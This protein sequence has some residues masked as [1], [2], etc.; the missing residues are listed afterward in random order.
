MK[1]EVLGLV[2]LLAVALPVNIKTEDSFISPI[3]LAQLVSK[4][5]QEEQILA[6]HFLDLTK[7]HKVNSVN[8]IFCDNIL[9]TLH[10]LEGDVDQFIKDSSKKL[11]QTNIL[12]EEV[13]EP[14]ETSFTLY[15]DEVFAFHLNI[16]KDY[17]DD[18]I[19]IFNLQFF[20]QEGFK[21]AGGLYGNGVCHLASLMNWTASE[22]GLEV[23]GKVRHSFA[24]IEDV[25]KE[26]GTSIRYQK[27]GGNSQNQNLY[28]KNTLDRPVIFRFIVDESKVNLRIVVRV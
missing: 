12:W 21:A 15:P 10:Y 23:I 20:A 1:Q 28:I 25:P 11:N 8:Q 19:K 2:T 5:D 9:L 27:S 24:P 22:A 7:R 13:R 3:P 4:N 26:Y 6:E 14:F 18:K 16:F 17:E